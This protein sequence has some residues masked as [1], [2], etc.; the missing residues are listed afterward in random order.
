MTG[1]RGDAEIRGFM[2]P[3]LLGA[4]AGLILYPHDFAVGRRREVRF[5]LS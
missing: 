3:H 1:R 5:N 4:A 2:S